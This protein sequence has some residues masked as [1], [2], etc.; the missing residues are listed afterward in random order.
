MNAKVP[1]TMHFKPFSQLINKQS[2]ESGFLCL[3]KDPF[4]RGPE[5][6]SS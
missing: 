4:R 3:C 1:N 2:E 5:V 6:N